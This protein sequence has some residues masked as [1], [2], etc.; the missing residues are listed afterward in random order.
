MFKLPLVEQGHVF[1][2]TDFM[3]HDLHV[4]MRKAI[5]ELR[6]D[7]LGLDMSWVVATQEANSCRSWV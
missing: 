7:L 2:S 3:A 4:K 1:T 6:R 5:L